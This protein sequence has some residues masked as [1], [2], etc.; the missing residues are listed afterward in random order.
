MSELRECPFE[1]MNECEISIN[2]KDLAQI[3]V[4]IAKKI[5]S[6]KHYVQIVY[7]LNQYKPTPPQP[8]QKE[9]VWPENEPYSY[10]DNDKNFC[11]GWNK[12]IE[13]CKQSWK[14]SL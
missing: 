4:D 7:Q 13:K 11:L 5:L 9:P 1:K 2:G 12:A 3:P 10:N 8:K 14:D 6:L